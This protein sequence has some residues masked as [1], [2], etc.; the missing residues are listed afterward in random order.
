MSDTAKM[1]AVFVGHGSP[2]NA[3]E[4]TRFSRAW[5][6]LGERLPK[7]R[8]ILAVSAHWFIERTAAT[9]NPKPKTIHDF[10]NFPKA[11][12]DVHYPAPGEPGLAAEVAEILAPFPVALDTSWGFDHAVWSVL[13]HMYPKADIPVVE[14]SINETLSAQEHLDLGARLAPLRD[15][16]VLLLGSGNIVHNLKHLDFD[17]TVPF[18]WAVRFDDHIRHALEKRDDQA[19][20]H[21]DRHPDA[22]IAAPDFEH[23]A[24]LLYIAGA[25]RDTDALRFFVEG[26][27]LGSVSMRGFVL[28]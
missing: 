24:P 13:V 19:I 20:V 3:I 15:R 22:A 4:E 12:F 23:Y 5:E 25:R 7:P 26:F 16:G 28:S 14:L 21:Y 18:D 2:M 1:P 10:G 6:L 11:L 17:A 27:D 8:A 9:A